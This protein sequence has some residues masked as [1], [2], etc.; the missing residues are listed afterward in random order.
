MVGVV[1]S[2]GYVTALICR[3]ITSEMTM[4]TSER[5]LYPD[6]ISAHVQFLKPTRPGT[7]TAAVEILK[8]GRTTATVRA[9][10]LQEDVVCL[11]C[12]ATCGDLRAAVARGPNLRPCPTRT[13]RG[14]PDL[15]GFEDCV[16]LPVHGKEVERRKSVRE[17]VEL[18]TS[19]REA[20]MF[21]FER[22]PTG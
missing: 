11:E 16:R 18:F 13:G 20:K 21:D 22:D 17:R 1:P 3:C 7:F 4:V 15:P 6:V 8:N 19:K 9:S 14:P 5:T 12:M 10:L 2:G